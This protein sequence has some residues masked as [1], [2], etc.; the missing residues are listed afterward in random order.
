MFYHYFEPYPPNQ[1]TK[2]QGLS[3]GVWHDW[4][5]IW[6]FHSQISVKSELH[7]DQRWSTAAASGK[8]PR[9]SYFIKRVMC[10][11]N[12]HSKYHL[13]EDRWQMIATYHGNSK[14]QS[15]LVYWVIELLSPSG[16][17]SSASVVFWSSI[18][19]L[20]R[21][22][23]ADCL[24][25]SLQNAES[26]GVFEFSS[27]W[28]TSRSQF[29]ALS[30]KQVMGIS[31]ILVLS[32]G[33]SICSGQEQKTSCIFIIMFSGFPV[34]SVAPSNILFCKNKTSILESKLRK[35]RSFRMF[36]RLCVMFLDE[37]HAPL[38]TKPVARQIDVWTEIRL[39]DKHWPKS[40]HR[41]LFI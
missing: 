5:L 31:W 11:E 27:F 39:D 26:A 12:H 33:T 14:M 24:C 23:F 4:N 9:S 18:E 21:S 10:S 28:A 32:Q 7:L 15:L 40:R 8:E 16:S 17:N 19:A 37:D 1:S 22:T 35:R 30:P 3:I 2:G 38:W 25:E 13:D 41:L 20:L 6:W 36:Q 29:C 34:A